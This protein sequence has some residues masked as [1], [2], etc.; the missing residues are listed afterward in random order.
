[1]HSSYLMGSGD[2][3]CPSIE[4]DMDMLTTELQF[5]PWS[6]TPALRGTGN[7]LGSGTVVMAVLMGLGSGV[8]R[9]CDAQADLKT[10][11]RTHEDVGR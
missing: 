11:L 9:L 3:F 7:C 6:C 8:T 2:Q 1:M 5:F 10:E 4:R